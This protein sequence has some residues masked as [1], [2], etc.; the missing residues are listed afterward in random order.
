MDPDALVDVDPRT[1]AR[2]AALARAF[3]AP[4]PRAT[5]RDEVEDAPRGEA[6]REPERLAEAFEE[7]LS[8]SRASFAAEASSFS[9]D[10]GSSESELDSDDSDDSD[11]SD[12]SD[13]VFF[14]AE[15][16][17]RE[18]VPPASRRHR[19]PYG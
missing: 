18:E 7:V 4:T 6:M 5:G 3:G 11:G 19:P 1:L 10:D 9:A 8:A 12:G 2:V 17:P 16:E 15:S 14:D 13:D